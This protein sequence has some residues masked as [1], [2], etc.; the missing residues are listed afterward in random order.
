MRIGFC[1]PQF[2]ALAQPPEVTRFARE[3]EALGAASLWVGDRLLAPVQ[4][5]V[6]YAGTDSFP[7]EFRWSL[8]PL[9]ALTAAAA[10]TSRVRL[11]TSV[12]NV[13]WYPP[14]LLA[15]S[16][17]AVDVLSGGRLIPGFGT[18]WSPEEFQ[19]TGISMTQRGERLDECLDILEALW[20]ASPAGHQGKHWTIPASYTDLKPVQRPRPPVYLGGY[21]PPALRR[22][23]RRADGWLPSVRVPAASDPAFLVRSLAQIRSDA[24][25]YGRDPGQIKVI[26][27]V[28]AAASAT[29][30]DIAAAV[31]AA[32][33]AIG[34]DHAYVDLMYLAQSADQ[35]LTVAGEVIDRVR[36]R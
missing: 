21:T 9:A 10:V 22:V 7:A 25:G 33:Q 36:G 28:N 27:R 19:A 18:G 5:A 1:L 35:A 4:P 23:A 3:A 6:G 13:P 26:L 15:R 32:E 34:T 31:A 12:L 20:T 11:G 29:A 17:T 8:D 30:A 16:L 14:A 24:A 2:G